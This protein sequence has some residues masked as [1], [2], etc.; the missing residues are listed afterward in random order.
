MAF[1]NGTEVDVKVQS[2]LFVTLRADIPWATVTCHN[3]DYG[4]NYCSR[5]ITFHLLGMYDAF[6][7]VLNS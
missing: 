1:L 7:C 4:D 5:N 2:L 6:A 3:T